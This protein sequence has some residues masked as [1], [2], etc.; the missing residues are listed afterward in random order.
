[1]TTIPVPDSTRDVE[2]WCLGQDPHG[3]LLACFEGHGL[4]RYSGTWE[5]VKASV[6][7]AESPIALTSGA[8]HV[9]L[10]YPH[11]Q[12]ALGDG[13]GFKVFGAAEG[14]QLNS[15]LTFYDA[16]GLVLAGGSDGLAFFDGQRFHSIRLRTRRTNAGY[17]RHRQ[18]PFWRLMA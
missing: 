7:P 1:M 12:I 5:Q 10:G 3:D 2:N 15:V 14:L 16:D 18:R 8:G 4:W 6:L 11:N 9:W 13:N 17:I